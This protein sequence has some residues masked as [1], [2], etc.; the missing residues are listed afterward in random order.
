MDEDVLQ[1]AT[2]GEL[3]RK[4]NAERGAICAS[5]C[6]PSRQVGLLGIDLLDF[7]FGTQVR[8]I[9]VAQLGRQLLLDLRLDLIDLRERK[10]LGVL[11]LDDMVAESSLHRLL[12]PLTFFQCLERF[13]ERLHVP[14]GFTPV[15]FA[16]QILGAG[17]FGFFLWRLPQNLPRHRDRQ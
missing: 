13:P 2:L 6:L 12:G 14:F 10:R 1:R 16:A 3:K 17:V 15:Q 7:G 8:N 11:Q 4:Q 5:F 9:V